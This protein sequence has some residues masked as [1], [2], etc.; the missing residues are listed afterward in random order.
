MAT[1]ADSLRGEY[2]QIGK[3]RFGDRPDGWLP[4]AVLL[5]TCAQWE[6]PAPSSRPR[7]ATARQSTSLR[8]LLID[9][10]APG[11]A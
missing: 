11:A 9:S 5:P 3:E 6:A 7:G 4:G 10:P 2:R 1:R 8:G